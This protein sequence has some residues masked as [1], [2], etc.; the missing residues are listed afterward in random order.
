VVGFPKP[1]TFRSKRWL[2]AV[3]TLDCVICGK[4]GPSQ[5]AHINEGKGIG[6]R[7]HD[8]WTAALCPECHSNIDQGKD[9]TREERRS[10]LQ[11]SVL[12]TIAKLALDDWIR[13]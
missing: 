9:M 11:K 10:A 12:L 8:C 5:A 1:V 3:S 4:Q 13:V 2:Q 6:L 7:T